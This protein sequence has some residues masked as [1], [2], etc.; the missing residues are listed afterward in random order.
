MRAQLSVLLLS[1]A[2]PFAAFAG[3]PA[4]YGAPIPAEGAV[5]PVSVAAADADAYA[6]KSGRFSG[7]ITQVCQMEGC[8]MMLEDNGQV[9]RVMMRD[10]AFSVP[11]D[12]SGNAEVYGV[13]SVKQLSREAIE[14]LAAE[15][16]NGL[17]PAERELRIE[18]TGVRIEG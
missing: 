10:H 11:K 9:A 3:E 8:W 7:R 1:L 13:L 4:T 6:G 12:A 15:S 2:L 18:A 14:H 5:V 16:A 17:A